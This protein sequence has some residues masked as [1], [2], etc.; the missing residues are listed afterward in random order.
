MMSEPSGPGVPWV[1]I[2]YFSALSADRSSMRSEIATIS[3]SGYV[4]MWLRYWGEM[5]P[6]PTTPTPALTSSP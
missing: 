3:S 6:A 1:A 2:P 4:A 5:F